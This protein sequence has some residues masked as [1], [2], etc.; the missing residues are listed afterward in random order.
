MSKITYWLNYM[1]PYNMT[2]I[3]ENGDNWALG[4]I[5]VHGLEDE[6]YGKELSVPP[7]DSKDWVKFSKWLNNFKS[8]T[9]LNLESIVSIYEKEV[10][11][12]ITWLN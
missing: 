11:K 1:G 6:P 8:E 2:W 4:R 12:K 5:D 3:K 9:M 7:M 10:N